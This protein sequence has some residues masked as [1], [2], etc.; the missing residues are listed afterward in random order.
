M[1]QAAFG[2]F[3]HVYQR[4]ED[5]VGD[6]GGFSGV[7]DIFAL[8]VFDLL[9][10]GFPEVGDEEN[11][12]GVCHGGGDG[13]GGVHV[14]LELSLLDIYTSIYMGHIIRQ[15]CGYRYLDL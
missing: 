2:C 4:R 3:R 11:G 15:D 12:V 9:L 13:G 1:W 7:G 8:G 6:A 5:E 14:R 10:G